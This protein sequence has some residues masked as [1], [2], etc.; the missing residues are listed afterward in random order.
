MGGCSGLD[1]RFL[2][3]EEYENYWVELG[4]VRDAIAL[5]LAEDGAVLLLDVAC[6]WGLYTFHLASYHP[7]GRVVAV[8]IVPSAFSNLRRRQP[9]DHIPDGIDPL[10]ADAAKLPI[11]DSVFDLS[12]SF[13]GMR[14]IH[15][16][17]GLRGVEDANGEM[18]RTLKRGGRIALA[19]TPPDLAETE[20][21]RIAIEVEGEVFGARSL[22]STFYEELFQGNGIE[23]MGVKTYSTGGKM[24]AEQAQRELRDG[25]EIAG[26][27]YKRDPPNFEEVWKR[28]GSTI[29]RHGYGMYSNITVFVGK[30]H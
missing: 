29:E 12:T 18:F 9:G 1:M 28:Y 6:G 15:M 26:D 8:D 23:L 25:I 19:V 4:G 5:D 3:D 16:T 22:S 13:L 7:E 20:D 2:S 11:R 24:T 10:M 21:Q 27:I 17:Q 30:K 14:D